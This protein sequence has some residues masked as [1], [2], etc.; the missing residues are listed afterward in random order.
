MNGLAATHT[1]GL[2]ASASA[3]LEYDLDC[4]TAE[5]T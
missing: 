4:E 1:D 5:R 3:D 2:N